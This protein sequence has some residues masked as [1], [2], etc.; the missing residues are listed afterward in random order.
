MARTIAWAKISNQRSVLMHYRRR[1]PGVVLDE[2]VAA[3]KEYSRQTGS[4]G[5]YKQLMGLEGSA[6]RVYFTAVSILLKGGFTMS[7]RNYHPPRDPVN[8]LLS[9]GYSLLFGEL[10]GLLLAHG[11]DPMLGCYHRVRYGRASLVN[12][13]MEEFRAPLVDR[14]VLYLVNKR[15][16][17]PGDFCGCRERGVT[18]DDVAR[19]RFFAGYENF[20]SRRFH[21]RRSGQQ[22]NFRG[23]FRDSV[24]SLGRVFSDDGEYRPFLYP[25]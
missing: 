25:S 19:R 16:V 12:D 17:H 6:S 1:R 21:D 18:L 9:F 5:G 4:V 8:A 7:G 23:L 3:L 2:A 13:L 22:R 20:V 11:F 14:L 10:N 24:L 15:V